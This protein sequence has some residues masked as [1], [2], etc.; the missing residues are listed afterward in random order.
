[1][2]N[3]SSPI[4]NIGK[5]EGETESNVRTKQERKVQSVRV[6]RQALEALNTGDLSRIHEFISPQYF[7]HESQVDSVRSKLR[8]P[9]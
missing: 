3:R 6:V 8:G 2:N 1:M 7:N 4:N 9:E 5:R